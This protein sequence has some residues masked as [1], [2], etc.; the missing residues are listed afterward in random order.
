[1]SGTSTPAPTPPQSDPMTRFGQRFGWTLTCMSILIA[2]VALYLAVGRD[3]EAARAAERSQALALLATPQAPGAQNALELLAREHISIGGAKLTGVR[4]HPLASLNG[5]NASGGDFS[6]ARM[7][8]A[9]LIGAQLENANFT[10]AQLGSASMSRLNVHGMRAMPSASMAAAAPTQGATGL[11]V[12]VPGRYG[13]VFRRAWLVGAQLRGSNLVGAEFAGANLSGASLAGSDLRGA[14]FAGANLS[15]TDLSGA[16]LGSL[17][18]T[19]SISQR[20]L[21]A[22]CIRDGSVPRLRAGLRPP[23][24]SCASDGRT[25]GSIAPAQ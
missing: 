4:L 7:N 20:Q 18:G 3:A 16:D 13:I 23:S 21:D 24:R 25:D 5:L 12:Q 17:A 9:S 1:M 19:G 10:D 2:A 14:T 6:R 22:A 15:N 8:G 11:A